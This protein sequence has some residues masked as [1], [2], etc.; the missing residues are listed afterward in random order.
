MIVIAGV[1]RTVGGQQ[2]LGPSGD[3]LRLAAGGRFAGR[4][5]ERLRLARHVAAQLVRGVSSGHPHT[6]QQRRTGSTGLL[7]CVVKSALALHI[8]FT[9]GWHCMFYPLKKYV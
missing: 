5:G 1:G 7:S 4:V 2:S 9:D 3:S 8:V 6:L